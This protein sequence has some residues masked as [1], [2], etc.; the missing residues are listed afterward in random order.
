[1]FYPALAAGETTTVAAVRN[2]AFAGGVAAFRLAFATAYRPRL[3][4]ITGRV[5]GVL[6]GVCAGGL[7]LAFEQRYP[8]IARQSIGVTTLALVVL[9]GGYTTGLIKV[10][11]RFRAAAI[12]GAGTIA[13]VYL[14]SFLSLLLD[15]RLPVIHGG[16]WGAVLWTGFI[17]L[18]ASLNFAVDLERIDKI[19][20]RQMPAVGA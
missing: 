17:A 1:M 16:G 20:D 11:A 7:A 2:A 4:R 3:A 14:A 5:T 18:I 9:I 6:G 12:A 19:E 10:T 15:M 13:L 8:G